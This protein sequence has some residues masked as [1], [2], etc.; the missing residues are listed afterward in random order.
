MFGVL[1]LPATAHAQDT[2]LSR[3]LVEL[4]QAQIT[5]APPQT[6]FS[7]EAHFLPGATQQLAPLFFSQQ[8]ITQLSTFPTGSS[9]GGF[10]YTFDPQL[11]TFT[12]AT[13]SFGPSF[14]E[15]ALTIGRG[16]VAFGVN[17]Q[18]SKYNSFEG[19]E[20]EDGDIR[21]FLRHIEI[22]GFFFEGDLVEAAVKLDLSTTTTSF[23][24]NY[25]LTNHVDVS[26]GVP[27]VSANVGAVIDAT[28]IQLSTSTSNPPI[29]VFPGG[30]LTA[31]FS[32]EGSAT[33]LGDL[34]VRTKVRVL[35]RGGGGLA[36]EAGVRLPTGDADNLLGAG[37]PQFLISVIG[38]ATRGRLAPHFNAG[39]TF[40]AD[41]EVDEEDLAVEMPNEFNYRVGTEFV[42]NPRVTLSADL[43]GRT[44]LDTGRLELAETTFQFTRQNG[45]TGTQVFEEFQRRT[46][47]L[48]SFILAA[49][50]KFN[51]TSNVLVS[52]NL[53]FG[54]NSAG[55]KSNVT[56]VFGFDFSY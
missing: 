56:P 55:F 8:I 41:P 10:T 13:D 31:Q 3:I 5:L 33:G 11:G 27:V 1:L 25:G 32:D 6:G 48:S 43:I 29:H 26:V 46:G 50:G 39:F 7:H 45:T 17:F 36:L 37:A 18:H 28:V 53:L 4:I 42:A 16:R 20:L 22:G 44:L 30:S 47:N 12:R 19:V 51:V 40:A 35:P 54:L 52:A 9:S 34:L 21:F 24:V 15:R 14:A 49:G 38:S 2:P 23:F